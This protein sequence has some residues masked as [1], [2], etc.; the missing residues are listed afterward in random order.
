MVLYVYNIIYVL[1]QENPRNA[2]REHPF[3]FR[4]RN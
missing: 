3:E 2:H 1:V 4:D